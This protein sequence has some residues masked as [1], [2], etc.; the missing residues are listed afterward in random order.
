MKIGASREL[1]RTLSLRH[2]MG[3]GG[4]VWWEATSFSGTKQRTDCKARWALSPPPPKWPYRGPP[5]NKDVWRQGDLDMGDQACHKRSHRRRALR[6]CVFVERLDVVCC[7]VA[8]CGSMCS[9]TALSGPV[10]GGEIDCL[11]RV[12]RPQ[13]TIRPSLIN[14][15]PPIWLANEEDG[16]TEVTYHMRSYLILKQGEHQR[17]EQRGLWSMVMAGPYEQYRG[18]IT[19]AE[20]GSHALSSPESRF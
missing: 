6:S 19:A 11:L 2:R 20:R 17:G 8:S 10:D 12:Q 5:V 4:W 7:E 3:R 13:P 9:V 1:Y 16:L 14:P 15:L 18:Q